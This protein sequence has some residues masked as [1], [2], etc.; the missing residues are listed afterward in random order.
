MWRVLHNH[1][2]NHGLPQDKV[3]QEALGGGEVSRTSSVLSEDTQAFQSTDLKMQCH[4][5]L[6]RRGR[7]GNKQVYSKSFNAAKGGV[8]SS[9]ETSQITWGDVL[10]NHTGL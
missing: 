3:T 9:N 6:Q 8:G 2:E 7:E 5:I 10:G 4:P 1:S